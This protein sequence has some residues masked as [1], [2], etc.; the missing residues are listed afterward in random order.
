LVAVEEG[1]KEIAARFPPKNRGGRFEIGDCV[2]VKN[3]SIM[4]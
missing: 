2:L 3:Q 1:R 4:I